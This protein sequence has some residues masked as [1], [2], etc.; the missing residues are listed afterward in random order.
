MIIYS[1]CKHCHKKIQKDDKTSGFFGGWHHMNGF[2]TCG[3]HFNTYK[4][5][6]YAEPASERELRLLKLKRIIK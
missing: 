2:A 5:D 6:D 3:S 4:K 1:I